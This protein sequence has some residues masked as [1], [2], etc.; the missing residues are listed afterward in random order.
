MEACHSG[1]LIRFYRLIV[2]KKAVFLS[3]LIHTLLFTLALY[4]LPKPVKMDV[5]RVLRINFE[6]A[7]EHESIENTVIPELREPLQDIDVPEVISEMTEPEIIVSEQ[8]AIPVLQKET[9]ISEKKNPALQ[10]PVEEEKDF[11][12]NIP[13]GTGSL[14]TDSDTITNEKSPAALPSGQ[15]EMVDVRQSGEITQDEKNNSPWKSAGQMEKTG[16]FSM[17]IHHRWTHQET[18]FLWIRS[19]SVL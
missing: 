4:L 1:C 11:P 16:L 10:N 15:D 19:G 14:I 3:I 8:E 5:Y 12:E 2:M 6:Q 18:A 17:V 13:D 7:L 9:V